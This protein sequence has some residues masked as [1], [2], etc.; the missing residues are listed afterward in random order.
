MSEEKALELFAR[1]YNRC[2][3]AGFARRLS[4]RA[5]YE[6]FNRL[7]VHDGR[8]SVLRALNEKAAELRAMD[9]PNK[10]WRGYLRYKSDMLDLPRCD[11]CVVLTAND[12]GRVLGVVRIRCTI[13][14][15]RAIR[16]LDPAKC[17]FTRGE[18]CGSKPQN[19]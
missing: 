18:Y 15:V 11:N 4:K 8:D 19:P 3:F 6:A 12:P 16:V 17:D 13:F 7:Y 1:C 2:D 10:A 9:R 14:G 5:V